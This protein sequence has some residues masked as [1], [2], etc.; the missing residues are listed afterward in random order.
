MLTLLE[1]AER[2]I[3]LY[4]INV[5]SV[6]LADSCFVFQ[7]NETC[8]M[9]RDNRDKVEMQLVVTGLSPATDYQL[10]L[11]PWFCGFTLAS[12]E[13]IPMNVTTR[14]L[15]TATDN[16]TCSG[17]APNA[18]WEYELQVTAT[19]AGE[20]VDYEPVSLVTAPGR[21]PNVGEDSSG[22][23]GIQPKDTVCIGWSEICPRDRNDFI[24]EYAYCVINEDQDM[25]EVESGSLPSLL[26]PN[27]AS[28]SRRIVNKRRYSFSFSATPGDLYRIEVWAVTPS[29]RSGTKSQITV[30]IPVTEKPRIPQQEEIEKLVPEEEITLDEEEIQFHI[31]N[32]SFL[33]DDSRGRLTTGMIV[34]PDS[35]NDNHFHS[36]TAEKQPREVLT[37][38]MIALL[39]LGVMAWVAIGVLAYFLCFRKTR[40]CV[41]VCVPMVLVNLETTIAKKQRDGCLLLREEYDQGSDYI[42]AN[43]IPLMQSLV[44]MQ[45][46]TRDD[47]YIATQGPLHSTMNDFWRMVWEHRVPIIVMLTQTV[48]RGQIKCEKYWPSEHGEVRQYGEVKVT[49]T[50]VSSLNDYNITIFSLRHEKEDEEHEVIHFHYLKWLDMTADVQLQTILDFVSYIRQHVRPDRSGPMIVHCSAGVG[51]TGTFISIDYVMQ[52]INER[53]VTDQ[54]DI[55]GFILRMRNYRCRMVQTEAAQGHGKPEWSISRDTIA[56]DQRD[57]TGAAACATEDPIV[58]DGNESESA[59][60]VTETE[61][62]EIDLAQDGAPVA[63]GAAAEAAAADTRGETDEGASG[64]LSA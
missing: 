53:P 19:V 49:T 13:P 41:R 9:A 58:T 31:K 2:P 10:S 6:D 50:S 47:E 16:G 52:F 20:K 36:P 40:A 33:F 63:Q 34:V 61:D 17:D 43:Y 30:R 45:G 3:G 21:V 46:Y 24:R 60:N 28:M 57:F 51:R 42:N 62:I 54:L 11:I 56:L 29:N 39:M 15:D 32:S 4:L 64:M 27:N 8:E 44:C 23:C 5:S 14:G 37:P 1:A 18:F 22:L 38:T 48:E 25:E 12:G 55:F 7:R 35:T 59:H 26:H